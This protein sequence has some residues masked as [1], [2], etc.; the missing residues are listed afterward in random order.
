MMTRRRAGSRSA[1]GERPVVKNISGK[2]TSP[3]P[4]SP[5]IGSRM[6]R[7]AAQR[8]ASPAVQRFDVSEHK[9][10][11]P[12]ITDVDGRIRA[13]EQQR[14]HD[15]CFLQEMAAVLQVINRGLDEERDKR[16]TLEAEVV[17]VEFGRRQELAQLKEQ[18][19]GEI[20]ARMDKFGSEGLGP[21]LD[22]KFT[23][24][25]NK[26]QALEADIKALRMHETKVEEYLSGLMKDRPLEGQAIERLVATEVGQVRD[27]VQK[28]ENVAQA[29]PKVGPNRPHWDRWANCPGCSTRVARLVV[30]WGRACQ[31]WTVCFQNPAD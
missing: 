18:I 31:N 15:H 19:L 27:M 20:P 5:G 26:L 13:L 29:I 4:P 28:C 23:E 16:I 22:E 10:I 9:M 7:W 30:G 14:A 17:K 21:K 8:A 25:T 12:D 11:L 1:S 2:R 3:R 24:A 6:V